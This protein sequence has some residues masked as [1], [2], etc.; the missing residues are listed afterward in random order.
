LNLAF[1]SVESSGGGEINLRL[2]L[3]LAELF[4]IYFRKGWMPRWRLGF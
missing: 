1:L 2:I 3:P 4:N